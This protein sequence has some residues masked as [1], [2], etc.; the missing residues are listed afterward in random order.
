MDKRP[1]PFDAAFDV[2]MNEVQQI[3]QEVLAREVWPLLKRRKYRMLS[4]NGAFYIEDRNGRQLS[5]DPKD[6]VYA[7]EFRQVL[8]VLN[9]EIPGL[10]VMCLGSLGYDFPSK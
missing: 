9:T 8:E 1:N 3:A 4:G 7:E 10:P 2:Y 5:T 6:Y